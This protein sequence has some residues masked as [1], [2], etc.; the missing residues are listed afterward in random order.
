M[1]KVKWK[2]NI[3]ERAQY[4]SSTGERMCNTTNVW[5]QEDN[6]DE[7]NIAL[8]CNRDVTIAVKTA[9]EIV[10]D[11]NAWIDVICK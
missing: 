2:V 4:N 6:D 1:D 10:D 5:I 3:D 7:W 8:M 9:Q 11:H